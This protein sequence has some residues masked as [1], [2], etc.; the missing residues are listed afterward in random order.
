LYALV[1]SWEFDIVFGVDPNF[2]PKGSWHRSIT[3]GFANSLA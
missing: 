3:T 2:K 1:A